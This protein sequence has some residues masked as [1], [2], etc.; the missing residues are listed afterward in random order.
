M[1]GATCYPLAMST[2]G[3]MSPRTLAFV[4]ELARHTAH[5]RGGSVGEQ[6]RWLLPS[7]VLQR[8]NGAAPKAVARQ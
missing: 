8:A 2:N 6:Q 3:R 7:V 1:V 5:K 4:K